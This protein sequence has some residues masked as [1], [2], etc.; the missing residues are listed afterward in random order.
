MAESRSATAGRAD[1]SAFDRSWIERA[2]ATHPLANQVAER[3]VELAIGGDP[4]VARVVLAAYRVASRGGEGDPEGGRT[5]LDHATVARSVRL[6]SCWL[7]PAGLTTSV[8]SRR[9]RWSHSP[10]ARFCSTCA[11]ATP[12]RTPAP[13]RRSR[14]GLKSSASVL[15]KA[16]PAARSYPAGHD[17]TSEPGSPASTA[18]VIRSQCS[19]TALRGRNRARPTR[20]ETREPV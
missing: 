17:R 13:S 7:M 18:A 15:A 2:P 20:T 1:V 12:M 5:T 11:S 9:G 6:G 19:K 3:M 10:A 16:A 4:E 8:G 14:R